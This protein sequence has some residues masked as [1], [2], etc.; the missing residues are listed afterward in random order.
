[1]LAYIVQNYKYENIF[2]QKKKKRQWEGPMLPLELYYLCL[3]I[4][5]AFKVRNHTLR[6]N[7]FYNLVICFVLEIVKNPVK[8][9]YE[10]YL[11]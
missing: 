6:Y 11:F 4:K 3:E 9:V 1:M 2:W 5:D 10:G 8:T 7:Y